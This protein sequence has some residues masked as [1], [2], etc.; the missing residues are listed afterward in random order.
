MAEHFNK[1]F[2]KIGKEISDSVLPT[3]K[4]A[5]SYITEN[6]LTP[7]FSLG[8]TGPTH[9][10]DFIKSFDPKKSKDLN[11]ISM[12]LLKFI[13][14]EISSPLAHI[15]NLSLKSGIFPDSLKLSRTVPIFKTGCPETC[16][17]YRPISLLNCISKS[18]KKW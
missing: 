6:N 16:D 13:A 7:N 9:V 15:F 17:N 10:A 2:T 14:I 11:G 12:Q 5:S 4:L 1:F 18:S 3:E 8:S